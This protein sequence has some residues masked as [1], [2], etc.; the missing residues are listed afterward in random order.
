MQ[1]NKIKKVNLD[2]EKCI[3][4]GACGMTAPDAFGFDQTKGKAF[5]KP[6][7]ENT[8]EGKIVDATSGCPVQAISF[9][10]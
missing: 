6:D 2:Q 1:E 5:V 4:C 10:K 7:A 9:E 8:E 3:G